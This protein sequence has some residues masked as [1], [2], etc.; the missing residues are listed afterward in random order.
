LEHL[1]VFAEATSAYLTGEG[2]FPERVALNAVTARFMVNFYAT[3]AEW[4]DWASAVVATWPDDP[5][6]A[7][8][9]WSMVEENV[10]RARRPES[11]PGK[12]RS[13]LGR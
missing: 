7:V 8:P 12:A 1:D 10:R 3:V 4:A 13:R 9:D 2:P 11:G 5:K 6:R